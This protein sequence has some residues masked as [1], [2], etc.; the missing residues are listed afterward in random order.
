MYVTLL[1]RLKV[2]VEFWIG[3]S[4]WDK[5]LPKIAGVAEPQKKPR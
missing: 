5:M 4:K 3:G 1:S 2:V